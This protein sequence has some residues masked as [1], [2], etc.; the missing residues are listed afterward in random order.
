MPLYALTEQDKNI[1][2]QMVEQKMKSRTNNPRDAAIFTDGAPELFIAML[3]DG[4]GIPAFD[5]DTNVPGV[6]ETC[7]IFKLK[8]Q[9]A[10][11]EDYEI[12]EVFDVDGTSSLAQAVYNIYPR[13][14]YSFSARYLIVQRD[15]SGSWLCEAP[16]TRYQAALNGNLVQGAT[17]TAS[18]FYRGASA[19]EDSGEDETVYEFVLNIDEMFVQYQKGSISWDE[20]GVWV[21]ESPVCPVADDTGLIP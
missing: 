16:P 9:T 20:G 1:I 10:G 2:A 8:E 19:W 15:K 12:E 18:I 21:F 17:A 13:P 11:D 14:W 4:E 7:R 5:P 6:N 3:P